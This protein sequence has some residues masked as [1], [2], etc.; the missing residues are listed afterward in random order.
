MVRADF[1]Q[2]TE[3]K[4]GDHVEHR[5]ARRR[6]RRLAISMPCIWIA[7]LSYQLAVTPDHLRG[8]VS[9]AFSLLIW[10]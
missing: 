5:P 4:P 6:S 8:R 1:R 3:V 10:A 2:G 9:T 7:A